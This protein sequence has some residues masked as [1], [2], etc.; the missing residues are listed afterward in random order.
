MV[1]T[2]RPQQKPASAR[3]KPTRE[4]AGLPPA[5][6]VRASVSRLR[7]L[8]LVVTVLM[9]VDDPLPQRRLSIEWLTVLVEGHLGS[10]PTNL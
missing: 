7:R 6:S 5:S 10:D 9:I 4:T 2:A 1:S 3:I 8:L